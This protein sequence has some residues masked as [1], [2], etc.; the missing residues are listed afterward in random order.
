MVGNLNGMNNVL[1]GDRE[2]WHNSMTHR[3]FALEW[4]F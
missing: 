4:R 2:N 3:K 1:L